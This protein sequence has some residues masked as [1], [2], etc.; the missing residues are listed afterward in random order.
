MATKKSSKKS[1]SR[2]FGQ[3]EKLGRQ[4]ARSL[5]GG[6]AYMDALEVLDDAMHK[7]HDVFAEGRAGFCEG[8]AKE[9]WRRQRKA[10]GAGHA[11]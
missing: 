11:V 7:F 10:Q 2:E 3:G 8:V 6:S 1:H 5:R 9:F 4:F